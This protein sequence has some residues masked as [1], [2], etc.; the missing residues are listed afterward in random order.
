MYRYHV[1]P[2][3]Y[4]GWCFKKEGNKRASL[5]GYKNEGRISLIKRVMLQLL[6]V[7]EGS[8]ICIHK[9]SGEVERI[10]TISERRSR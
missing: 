10:I 5:V 1:I 4:G 7:K 9:E 8:K 2:R 6:D 3:P